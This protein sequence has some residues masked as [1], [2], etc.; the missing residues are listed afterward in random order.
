MSK[1]EDFLSTLNGDGQF[2]KVAE[3]EYMLFKFANQN[4]TIEAATALNLAG[5]YLCK[6]ANES[7]EDILGECGETL[8]AAGHN[9]STG[10]TKI[11]ADNSAGAVIDMVGTQDGLAKVAAVLE[12]IALETEDNTFTKVAETVVEINNTLFD[13]LV[14]LAQNDDSVAEYLSSYYA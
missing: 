12:A 13:E 9:M 1:V 5:E 11:A 4:E 8:L 2:D 14:E 10:L 6:L 3:E 7:G